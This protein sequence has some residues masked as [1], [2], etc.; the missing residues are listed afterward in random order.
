MKHHIPRS[1]DSPLVEPSESTTDVPSTI[2]A[3]QI[4]KVSPSLLVDCQEGQNNCDESLWMITVLMVRNLESLIHHRKHQQYILMTMK[5]PLIVQTLPPNPRQT[6]FRTELKTV[7]MSFAVSIDYLPRQ[8][9]LQLT[10]L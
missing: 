5:L 8:R 1:P 6:Q 2:D 3:L 4:G 9:S 10:P 7:F